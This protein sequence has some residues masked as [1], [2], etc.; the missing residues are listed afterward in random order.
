[1]IFFLLPLKLLFPSPIILLFSVL[2]TLTDILD[3]FAPLK[4]RTMINRPK[5]PWFND[6]IKN[7]SVNVVAL[8]REPVRV[9]LASYFV[10]LILCTALPEHTDPTKLANKFGT[11]TLKKIEIIKENL[12]K[13]QVQEP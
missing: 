5:V 2:L 10:W 1:M 8:K 11:F 7:S 4:T 12:D 6:D 9:T 3:N 13:F